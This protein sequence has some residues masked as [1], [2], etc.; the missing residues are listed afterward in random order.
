MSHRERERERDVEIY[1]RKQNEQ[2]KI[3]RVTTN[4]EDTVYSKFH[5]FHGLAA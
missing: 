5:K 2:N 3:D 1:G 4:Q